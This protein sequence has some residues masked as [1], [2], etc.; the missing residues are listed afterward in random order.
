MSVETPRDAPRTHRLSWAIGIAAAALALFALVAGSE[1][2][3]AHGEGPDSKLVGWVAGAVVAV[4]GVA[5][6]TR[7]SAG[8]GRAAAARSAPSAGGVVRLLSSIVGYLIVAF[9]VLS[10]LQV[11]IGH[12]LVGAGIA[13]VVLGIAAQ[14][15]LGNVF[16]GL[17]LVVARPFSVGDRIR[18]RSGALGGIFDA[19]VLELSL[20]YVS[21]ATTDGVLRVPN[22]AMLAAGILRLEPGDEGA[23][24]GPG[25]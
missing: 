23:V 19:S 8:F 1:F 22:S 11:G 2:G 24:P 21:L 14:Q 13:G 20:T 15:S 7:L 18:I 6:T 12:L 17:V 16:A 9:S 25:L 10:V 4:A 3:P 5:A